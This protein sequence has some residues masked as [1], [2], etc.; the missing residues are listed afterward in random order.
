MDGK[1]IIRSGKGDYNMGFVLTTR[2]RDLVLTGMY[3]ISVNVSLVTSDVSATV[4]AVTNR[5][6]VRSTRI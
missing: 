3:V 4:S 1:V 2:P 6:A 5:F